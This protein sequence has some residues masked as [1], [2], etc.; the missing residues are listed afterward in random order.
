[1]SGPRAQC[2]A[3]GQGWIPKTSALAIRSPHS[4]DMAR[5]GNDTTKARL[6]RDENQGTSI[7]EWRDVPSHQNTA[8][9]RRRVGSLTDAAL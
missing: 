1:M 7:S 8:Y 2:N 3:P 5:K 6:A 4:R 9:E